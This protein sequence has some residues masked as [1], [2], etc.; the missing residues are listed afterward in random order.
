M[1][2]HRSK[3]KAHRFRKVGS[4][5][6]R[7]R[8][9]YGARKTKSTRKTIGDERLQTGLTALNQSGSILVAAK[10]AR[11]TAKK[12]KRAALK[13]KAIKKRG[14]LWIVSRDLFREM[15]IYSDSK[16]ITVKLRLRSAR[17]AG[18]Y[19]SAVGAFLRSNNIRI[20]DEFIDRGVKDIAGKRHVFETNPN[21]LYQLAS[22]TDEAFEAVYRI[23]VS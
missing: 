10:A 14:K 13:K 15:L 7:F 9:K 11:T 4:N 8:K 5:K 23:V 17:Q 12:F 3:S 2:R 21:V 20:L 6:G 16:Q 19:M 1:K 18:K 22:S